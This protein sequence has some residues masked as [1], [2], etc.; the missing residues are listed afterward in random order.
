MCVST[1]DL[2][3]NDLAGPRWKMLQVVDATWEA[4][5][6]IPAARR[7]STGKVPCNLEALYA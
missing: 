5:L 2:V 3:I 7:D 6:T 1:K 4:M